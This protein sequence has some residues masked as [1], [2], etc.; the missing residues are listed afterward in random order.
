MQALISTQSK[1][2]YY[3][4]HSQDKHVPNVNGADQDEVGLVRGICVK[5]CF[6]R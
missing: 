5:V 4:P 3:D 1:S 6:L 2:K